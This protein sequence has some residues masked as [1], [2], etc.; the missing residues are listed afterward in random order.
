MQRQRQCD[1][2]GEPVAEQQ[3]IADMQQ[4]HDCEQQR[5]RRIQDKGGHPA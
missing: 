4:Q 2:D 5:E 1:A 3:C